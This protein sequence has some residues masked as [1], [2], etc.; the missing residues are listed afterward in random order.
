M[1]RYAFAIAV[2]IAA[3]LAL[4]A[5]VL[6]IVPNSGTHVVSTVRIHRDIADVFAFFTMPKNWPRWHP[7]SISVAGATDHSLAVGE[8]VTEEFRMGSGKGRVV[9]RVTERNAPSLWRIEGTPESG[10]AR[11]TITYTLRMDGQDTVFERNMHYQFNRLW[12]RVLDPLF[13]R[14]HIEQESQQALANA[15]QI[16]E[17]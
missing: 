2:A 16:L 6:L 15:K 4:G 12:L 14:R 11:V 10:D 13:I 8:E 1:R 5:A 9:W 3:L 7:A 17:H